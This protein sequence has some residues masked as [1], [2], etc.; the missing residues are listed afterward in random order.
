M[1]QPVIRIEN[2]TRTYHV[3]DVD[4][5]ALRGVS[6]TIER[7]EFVA[8][9]GASGSGKSTLMGILGFLDH[10]TGGEYGFEGLDVARLREPDLAG[11]RGDRIGFVFQSFNLLAR[12][13][14]VE[15]VALPLFYS[16]AGSTKRSTRLER[17]RG[18]LQLVGLGSAARQT[19][20]QLSGGQQQRVAIARALIN[21]PSLLLADATPGNLAAH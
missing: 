16:A 17:A 1:S 14:A 4:V 19:P 20:S 11:I 8:I 18:A 13:S 21:A 9:M 12:A 15:N 6:L 5:H 7:G 10:P 2:P 3:G